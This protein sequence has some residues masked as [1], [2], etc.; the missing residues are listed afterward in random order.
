MFFLV[1]QQYRKP[2]K[3]VHRCWSIND[4][5]GGFTTLKVRQI[6][7]IKPL[8]GLSGPRKVDVRTAFTAFQNCGVITLRSRG[9][10]SLQRSQAAFAA[11]SAANSHESDNSSEQKVTTKMA[12]RN[13]AMA[14][15]FSTILKS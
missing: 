4:G 7:S 13:Y 12:T 9:G 3:H 5:V 6:V 15:S 10:S 1:N 2:G 11:E 14:K 8:E